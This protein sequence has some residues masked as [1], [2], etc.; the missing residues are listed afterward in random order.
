MGEK[1]G[2]TRWLVAGLH[3][4]LN[5]KCF[6]FYIRRRRPLFPS[7]FFSFLLAHPLRP[8]DTSTSIVPHLFTL[9]NFA[10]NTTTTPTHSSVDTSLPQKKT[11]FLFLILIVF[12]LLSTMQYLSTCYL[13]NTLTHFSTFFFYC[14]VQHFHIPERNDGGGCCNL[15]DLYNNY[16][17]YEMCI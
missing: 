7:S 4:H 5:C 9:V 6:L 3:S 13:F 1:G 10:E 16:W 15:K 17:I 12:E 8:L 2:E 11:F 14:I